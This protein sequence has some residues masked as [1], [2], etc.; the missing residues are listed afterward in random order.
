VADD[1]YGHGN[2]FQALIFTRRVINPRLEHWTHSFNR[3]LGFE[4]YT[5]PEIPIWSRPL[6]MQQNF[7][8]QHERLQM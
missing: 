2:R 6:M 4:P 1:N 7:L 3:R 8:R 5:P